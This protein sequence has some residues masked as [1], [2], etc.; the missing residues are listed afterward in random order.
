[1]FRFVFL[2]GCNIYSFLIVNLFLF[3]SLF[4]I[5]MKPVS[6]EEYTLDHMIIEI[7]GEMAS[8]YPNEVLSVVK[9]DRIRISRALLKNE[10]LGIDVVNLEGYP[11]RN[12]K[13]PGEDRGFFIDTSFGFL[14]GWSLDKKGRKYRISAKSKGFLH[15]E[16]FIE[17]LE[18]R[19]IFAEV[20]INNKERKVK[21]GEVL[22][23]KKSDLI[24]VEKVVTN[25]EKLDDE[26]TFLIV[27]LEFNREVD[28]LKAYELR[29]YRKRMIFA[30]IPLF[31]ENSER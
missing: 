6:S 11:G 15:G 2:T 31:I 5:E 9:G 19:L 16:V 12:K 24:K 14:R 26:A 30:K 20:K 27:P 29:F 8:V 17:L 3:P 21:D 4:A 22:V 1:M 18:P 13:I 23:L 7:N 28:S 10:A 25:M